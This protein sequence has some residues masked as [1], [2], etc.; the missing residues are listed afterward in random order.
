M[1][2]RAP[3]IPRPRMETPPESGGKPGAG[4]G[5]AV[6]GG[7]PRDLSLPSSLPPSPPPPP[8]LAASRGRER[9][10]WAARRGEGSVRACPPR[11]DLPRFA[12]PPLLPPIS[13]PF[14]SIFF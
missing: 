6:S 9:E 13:F 8:D 4:P 10:R 1:A 3:E 5:F 11:L 2:A 14:P 12:S 7:G